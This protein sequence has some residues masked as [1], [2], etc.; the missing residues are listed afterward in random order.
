MG[1]IVGAIRRDGGEEIKKRFS[2][3]GSCLINPRERRLQVIVRRDRLLN[4]SRE[5]GI[6]KVPPP[7]LRWI[8][9]RLRDFLQTLCARELR[10]YVD[11]W[12]LIIGTNKHT[13]GE[14]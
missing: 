7:Q 6:I 9:R 12:L 13:A 10:R 14:L 2:S 5:V 8:N 3:K 4:Q 11:R 1:A